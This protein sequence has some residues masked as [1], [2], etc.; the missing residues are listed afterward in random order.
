[1]N[2]AQ[3][4]TRPF[5]VLPGSALV[6]AHCTKTGFAVTFPEKFKAR[7]EPKLLSHHLGAAGLVGPCRLPILTGAYGA[8]IAR[9]YPALRHAQGTQSVE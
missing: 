4:R 2:S 3:K 9:H 1:M 6:I 8:R 5:A 7:A